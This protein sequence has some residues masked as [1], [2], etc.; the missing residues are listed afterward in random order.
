[1]E[2]WVWAI[3]PLREYTKRRSE[4]NRKI[5]AAVM[6]VAAAMVVVVAAAAAITTT[7]LKQN[8]TKPKETNESKQYNTTRM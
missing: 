6:A 7:N 4:P 2:W 8:Q 5:K 3:S 1:M